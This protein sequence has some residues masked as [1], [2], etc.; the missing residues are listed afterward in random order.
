MLNQVRLDVRIHPAEDSGADQCRVRIPAQAKGR[1]RRR[2]QRVDSAWPPNIRVRPAVFG[3]HAGAPDDRPP[4]GRGC[5]ACDLRKG[6]GCW[7]DHGA[8]ATDHGWRRI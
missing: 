4:R 6:A 2:R 7:A 1:R 3:R 8:N 5:D